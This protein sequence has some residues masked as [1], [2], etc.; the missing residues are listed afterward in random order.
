MVYE[1]FGGVM[2]KLKLFRMSEN[3]YDL[4]RLKIYDTSMFPKLKREEFLKENH[5]RFLDM[6][7]E[8]YEKYI[9]FTEEY[10]DNKA[11]NLQ[12]KHLDSLNNE[13][14]DWR[15]SEH[16]A[17]RMFEVDY[18]FAQRFRE[19]I[20]VQLFSFFERSLV[21]SCEMY[22]SNKE[23]DESNFNENPEKADF[24]Y[25]KVFLKENTGVKLKDINNELDFFAKLKTLRNRIVHHKTSVFSDDEKKINDIR[26]LSKNRFTLIVKQDITSSYS[27]YFDKPKFILE[28]IEKIKSLYY[29]L[30][31]NGVYY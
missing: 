17:Q 25:A 18:E 11:E 26:A 29:K 7:L 20:I 6:A 4:N 12:K 14:E 13:N 1:F 8:S 16:Y 2:K 24:D 19:S 22:Y 15:V 9:K 3:K 27:L 21:S 23:M 28:I 5:V 10:L 30:G 31:Q